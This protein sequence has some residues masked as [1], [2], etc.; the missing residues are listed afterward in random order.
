MTDLHGDEYWMQIALDLAR[1]AEAQGEVPVGAVVV[2]DEQIIGEGYNQIITQCDPTA[3][4]EVVA[5]RAAAQKVNNYRL[6]GA[7][8]YVTLE[9]CSMCAG[10]M[11]HSR[12][13]RCVYGATEPKAGVLHSKGEFFKQDFLNHRVDAVGGICAAECSALLSAFF[14]KR[15]KEKKTNTL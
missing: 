6:V 1:Q 8:L 14:A 13:A 9:P 3:H 2:L 10:S 7:T 4:A 5:L 11:V 15:R 12:I